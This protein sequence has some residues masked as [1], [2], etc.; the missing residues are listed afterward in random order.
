MGKTGNQYVEGWTIEEATKLFDKAYDKSLEDDYDFI[1]EVA[2]DLRTYRDIFT[3][4]VAKFPQLKSKY[5]EILSNLESNCFSHG[6]K[7]LIKDSLAIMNLKSNYKWTDRLSN[8][9]TTKG[10]PINFGLKDLI[11]NEP[12]ET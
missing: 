11:D 5:S 12:K 9:L 7:G 3:Y 2:R 8:D 1:G 10:K 4:L 6:K